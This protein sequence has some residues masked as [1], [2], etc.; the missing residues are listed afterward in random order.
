MDLIRLILHF[1]VTLCQAGGWDGSS[2]MTNMGHLRV[3]QVITCPQISIISWFLFLHF[4]VFFSR[5]VKGV[6]FSRGRYAKEV[7]FLP[8][9]DHRKG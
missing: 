6:L 5:F 4:A 9:M 8:K 7:S 1:I 2:S 3:R